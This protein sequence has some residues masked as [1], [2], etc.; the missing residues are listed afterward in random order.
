LKIIEIESNY[1]RF[2]LIK[3]L[4]GVY[5]WA[6]GRKYV[7]DWLDNNMHGKGVYTWK[8]GRKYDGKCLLKVGEY[9][10]DKKHGFG[11]YHWADGRRYEGQ[12]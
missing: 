6:D 9:L 4:K 1:L 2:F 3:N 8:D 11:I 10:N 5:E 7:G 12:W